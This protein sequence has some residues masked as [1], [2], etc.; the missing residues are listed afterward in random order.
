MYVAVVDACCSNN[1]HKCNQPVRPHYKV[2]K[3]C[4][5]TQKDPTFA[6]LRMLDHIT[7]NHSETFH[8]EG[9]QSTKQTEEQKT[10]KDAYR[11]FLAL[12]LAPCCVHN[13]V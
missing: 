2:R 11:T 4:T 10:E 3:V 7:Q 12:L 8:D 5:H 6:Y 13:E 9:I 1:K